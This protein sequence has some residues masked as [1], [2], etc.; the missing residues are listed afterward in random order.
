MSNFQYIIALFIL[1]VVVI[2]MT[3]IFNETTESFR[4]SSQNQ[5]KYTYE[6]PLDLP[7]NTN[8]RRNNFNKKYSVN[9]N[10]SDDVPAF[11]GFP[12]NF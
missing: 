4:S 3:L 2:S 10:M 5:S 7:I 11:F 6:A 8:N 1:L 9:K 12:K